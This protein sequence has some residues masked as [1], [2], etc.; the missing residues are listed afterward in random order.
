MRLKT[1]TVRQLP[2]KSLLISTGN[3]FCTFGIRIRALVYL[4]YRGA[5]LARRRGR[6]RDLGSPPRGSPSIPAKL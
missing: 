4:G 1:A 3:K 6:L 2:K 5:Q